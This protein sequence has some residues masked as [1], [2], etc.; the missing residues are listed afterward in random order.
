M[1]ELKKQHFR[2]KAPFLRHL[3]N[4]PAQFSKLFEIFWH[5]TF[6]KDEL[7]NED[8]GLS[9]KHPFSHVVDYTWGTHK[10]G[11]TPPSVSFSGSWRRVWD[12]NSLSRVGN[13]VRTPVLC[14][15]DE[16]YINVSN[17][18]LRG[19]G[20]TGAGEIVAPVRIRQGI[21]Q[22]PYALMPGTA[23]GCNDGL[24][25]PKINELSSDMVRVRGWVERWFWMDIIAIYGTIRA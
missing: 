1:A 7:K 15:T 25:M 8:R 19:K 12:N 5:V 9:W 10:G 3:A 4:L 20:K 18:T 23:A 22:I 2:K 16:S 17:Q 21:R 14:S 24:W 11:S 13:E 6:Y